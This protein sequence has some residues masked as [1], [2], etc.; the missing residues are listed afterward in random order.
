M[1]RSRPASD[2]ERWE[3]HG[4]QRSQPQK[5]GRADGHW[6]TLLAPIAATVCAASSLLLGF[7]DT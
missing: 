2:L 6:C 7:N 3:V 5:I 1:P 4:R